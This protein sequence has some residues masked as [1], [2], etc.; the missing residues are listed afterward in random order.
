MAACMSG[1][2]TG[3]IAVSTVQLSLF[4]KACESHTRIYRI[5]GIYKN[6]DSSKLAAGAAL[7][8][9][10]RIGTRLPEKIPKS[11][12]TSP[13][14]FGERQQHV[15]IRNSRDHNNCLLY[16]LV[17]KAVVVRKVGQGAVAEVL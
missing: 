1:L 16:S 2:I 6:S 12:Q 3:T 7:L 5:V 9:R 17:D 4:R 8:P 13:G 11:H 10:A 15:W 14:T